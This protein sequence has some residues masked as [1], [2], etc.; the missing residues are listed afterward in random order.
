[1]D[2]AA[3]SARFAVK[4]IAEAERT[5]LP[6]IGFYQRLMS[7]M[8]NKMHR[9]EKRQAA[10]YATEE[11]LQRSLSTPNMIRD[12]MLMLAAMQLDKLVPPE[13]TVTL[14]L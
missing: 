9:N 14:P 2:N 10:R 11:S 4:A 13:R 8:V 6:S 7:G 12:G 3:L 5:G 1:M